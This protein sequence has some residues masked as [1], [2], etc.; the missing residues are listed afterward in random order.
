MDGVKASES[1]LVDAGKRL[2][3]AKPHLITLYIANLLFGWFGAFGLSA[4]VGAVTSTSLYS[5]RLVRG[6]DLGVFLDLIN[7]PEI[8]PYSLVPTALALSGL[9]VVFQLFLTGGIITQYLSKTARIEQSRF[10]GACGEHFWRLLRLALVFVVVAALVAGILQA[11]SAGLHAATDNSSNYRMVLTLQSAMLVVEA[12][13]LTSVRMWFDLAQTLLIATS[14]RR[15]RPS[16]G[17][18]FKSARRASRLYGSYV[19]L[20]ILT[21][22]VVVVGIFLWWTVAPAFPAIISFLILQSTLA[23]L[24]LMRWWQQAIAAVWYERNIPLPA[25]IESLSF[26]PL[27]PE[28]AVPEMPLSQ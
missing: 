5:E 23:C 18:G 1:L 25:A 15:I 7:R 19:L 11:L 13:A 26:A 16:I 20:A 17:Y 21:A 6:F 24:L 9:F 2:M 28:S 3:T 22:L 12:L 4:Q 14:A 27:P 10:Y 8:T